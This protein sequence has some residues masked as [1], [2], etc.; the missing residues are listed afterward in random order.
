MQLHSVQTKEK[1]SKRGQIYRGMSYANLGLLDGGGCWRCYINRRQSSP[2][3]IL[4]K[5]RRERDKKPPM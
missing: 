4:L 1:P 3:G 5:C 2:K